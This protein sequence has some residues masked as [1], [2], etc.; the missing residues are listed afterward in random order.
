MKQSWFMKLSK[1]VL[2]EKQCLRGRNIYLLI[3]FTF[4]YLFIGCAGSVQPMC[5]TWALHLSTEA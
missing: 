5:C 3:Q 4:I 2:Q 1:K